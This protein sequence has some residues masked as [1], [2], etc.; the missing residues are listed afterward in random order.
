MNAAR[1]TFV[2]GILTFVSVAALTGQSA[3][4]AAA[5]ALTPAQM[6][7]FLLNAKII[8]SRDAGKGVTGTTRV[9]LSDGQITHDAQIQSVDIFKSVFEAG[10]A[11]E[12]NFRDSYRYNIA[13][14]RVA[15]LIGFN[16]VPMSVER[17]VN[18]KKSAVTWWIDDVMM[19]EGQRV[20][21]K[22]VGPSPQRFAE[23][24]Q[25]MKIFDELI[26]NKDRNS[27]N[28]LWT[29]DWTMWLIDHTR[30]FRLVREL[31]RPNEL[32]RCDRTLLEGM[33]RM[34]P[35][36]LAKAVGDSLTA[37]EQEALLARRDL[38]VQHFDARVA[39]LGENVLFTR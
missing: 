27:G 32:V 4:P 5:P 17:D 2:T 37:Q 22:T 7:A 24:L 14:Y 9:T 19:D 13:A 16:S 31:Q 38:L 3:P 26:L 29:K 35:D 36:S 18:G 34:T 11:S 8:S 15:R 30:S 10:A 20:K 33:R 12:I 21:K 23:Q 28:L 1:R 39:K 25:I 6:E